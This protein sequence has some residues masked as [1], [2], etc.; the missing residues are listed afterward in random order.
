MQA[1][2]GNK[3]HATAEFAELWKVMLTVHFD[4]VAH[5]LP[6]E[7]SSGSTKTS[8]ANTEF[9]IMYKVTQCRP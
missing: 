8:N 6:A 2:N 9:M 7:E 3:A 5:E 1:H 4:M